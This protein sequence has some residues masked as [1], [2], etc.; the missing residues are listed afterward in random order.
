M[1]QEFIEAHRELIIERTR[2]KVAA[3]SAPRPTEVEIQHGVPLFLEQLVSRLRAAPEAGAG[4][5]GASATLHGGELLQR[6]FTI[7]QVVHDYGDV[8]QAITELAVELEM[9][10]TT[11]DFRTLNLCLDIAIA[12]AVTEFSRQREETIVGEGVEHLGFMA[13]E[14]R[15]LLNKATLAFEV[16]RSGSVGLNGSTGTILERSILQMRD[17]VNRSLAEVRLEAGL[18]RRERVPVSD[19]LEE[20]EIAVTMQA[21]E[22]DIHLSI[23]PAEPG[24]TVDGDSQILASIVTNLMQ[25]ACKFSR[26]HGKVVLRVAATQARVLFEV[27]DECGGLPGGKAEDL[28]RPY[29]QRNDDRRGLGLGLPISLKGAHALGG[30]LTV[31][32]APGTGCIFTLDMPRSEPV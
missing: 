19:I 13:H 25:N 5:I 29:A 4:E 26:P 24:L 32:D 31:R 12:E 17:L 10:I 27:A 28:F 22:R 15:N 20:V 11:E 7:G 1:L 18:P 6:G 3:R 16:V 21:R 8:C 30:E 9:P 2:V 14:L 23:D